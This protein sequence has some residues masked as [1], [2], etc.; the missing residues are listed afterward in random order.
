MESDD[1]LGD[2]LD[3]HGLAH[4]RSLPGEVEQRPHHAPGTHR[5]RMNDLG[6]LTVL[7]I[8]RIDLEQL[9]ECGDGRERVIQLVRHSGDQHAELRE[10]VRLEEPALQ[11]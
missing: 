11:Q 8:F 1:P 6:A 5:L 9:C 4:P 3:R 7:G 2:V 10:P